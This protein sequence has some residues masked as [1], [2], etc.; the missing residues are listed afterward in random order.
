[1]LPTR[2]LRLAT[3]AA[4]AVAAMPAARAF[5]VW[6]VNTSNQLVRFDSAAPASALSTVAIS[7]LR[8]SDGVTADPF[9]QI[10][11]LSFSGSTL[12]AI[13]NNANFYTLNTTT[14]AATLVSSSFSPAGFN[15]ALAYDP[16]ISGGG[17]RFVSDARENYRVSLGGVF[18]AGPSVSVAT[19]VGDVNQG[20]TLALSGLAIDVDFG[21]GYAFDAN[22]DTL[23]VT[24]DANFEIFSTVGAL[25][26][27]F[28]ALA[29]LDFV[30]GSTLF[31]ALSTDS[32]TS[33]LYTINTATGAATLVGAF[34]TGVTAIAI[35]PSAIPEPSTFAALAGLAA[36][37]LA[38]SRRRRAVAA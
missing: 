17:F 21:T 34:G 28:T 6:A 26:G 4:V 29:S 3:T 23:L 19:G 38:A 24:N 15:G 16:F 7:G 8:Q 32:A 14:G 20:A 9:G 10:A 33:S 36:L 27:D 12:Y 25:G 31:A 1:M 18:T 35:N 37:G 13:D 2:T 30:D 11:E 5:E 22:L